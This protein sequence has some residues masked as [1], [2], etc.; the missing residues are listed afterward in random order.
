MDPKLMAD[1]ISGILSLNTEIW[2]LQAG[3]LKF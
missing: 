1:Y 3:N 2:Q